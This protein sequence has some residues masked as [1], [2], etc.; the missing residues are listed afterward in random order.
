LGRQRFAGDI[1]GVIW[2]K[3]HAIEIFYGPMKEVKAV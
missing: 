2:R 1:A 3:E